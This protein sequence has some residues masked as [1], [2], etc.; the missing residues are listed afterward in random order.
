MK[1]L[2]YASNCRAALQVDW[3]CAD[4]NWPLL[5]ALCH[6]WDLASEALTFS[7]L[8]IQGSFPSVAVGTWWVPVAAA[9]AL[10][11]AR[12]L[13][14]HHAALQCQLLRMAPEPAPISAAG[15]EG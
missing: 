2:S 14:G 3:L 4:G 11:A 7:A 1:C 12:R 9:Q 5:A 13:C 8:S 6:A 15:G 10:R